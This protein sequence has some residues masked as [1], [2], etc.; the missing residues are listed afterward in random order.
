MTDL[1]ITPEDVD[2]AFDV[3]QAAGWQLV[4]TDGAIA[5]WAPEP[6][7]EW[8]GFTVRVSTNEDEDDATRALLRRLVDRAADRDRFVIE[9]AGEQIWPRL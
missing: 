5:L 1:R 9:V 2:H 7:P 6:E 4:D 8:Y 3:L